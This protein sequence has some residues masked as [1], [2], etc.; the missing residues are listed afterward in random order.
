MKD[1]QLVVY[2]LPYHLIGRIL[3]FGSKNIGSNPVGVTEAGSSPVWVAD[4]RGTF[5][6]TK[7][8]SGRS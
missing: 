4:S 8:P 2:K 1:V 6:R 3:L 5:A 7:N